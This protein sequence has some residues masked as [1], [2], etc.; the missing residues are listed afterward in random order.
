VAD[1][2]KTK[3]ITLSTKD[4]ITPEVNTALSPGLN[5]VITR[6]GSKTFTEKTPLSFNT[7]VKSDNN[8][9]NSVKK[10]IQ[11]GKNGEKTT[12]TEV[13]YEDGKEVDRKI[14]AEAITA[15]PVDK[16]ISQGTLPVIPISRGGDAIPYIKVFKAKATAYSA[17]NG[18]GSTYSASGKLSVRNPNGYSTIAVDPSV[19]PMGSKVY[20]EGYG[21]AIAAD[22][23][24]AI[25]GNIIDVFFD[26]NAEANKWA[27][28]TVT[29]YMLK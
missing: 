4:K 1:L 26:T 14:V 16:I 3:N 25:K 20:V 22:T 10:T 27:V 5:I 15:K 7:I 28:K 8:A 12:T 19:I 13:T 17:I 6:V 24:S 2:L 9:A 18:I 21:L 29:V 23:G 11:N